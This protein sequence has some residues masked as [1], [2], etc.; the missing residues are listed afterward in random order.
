MITAGF[1]AFDRME[2]LDFVGPYEVFGMTDEVRP[3]SFRTLVLGAQDRPVRAYHGL[4]VL[5]EVTLEEAPPLDLLVVP[6]GDGRKEAS[7]DPEILDFLRRT[8]Q[9][10]ALVASVCTGA[11][12]LAAAGLLEGREAT[13]H[14]HF[15]GELTGSH[16][17]IRLVRRRWVRDGNVAT[18]GGVTCGIDLSLALVAE[19]V[20]RET[21]N[22]CAAA[23]TRAAAGT[24]A[25]AATWTRA[26][27]S[28]RWS[29]RTALPTFKRARASSTTAT[30]NASTRK[31]STRR[32]R[33]C[34][35]SSSPRK[36]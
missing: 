1:L 25:S 7:R 18:A 29:S 14:H 10:G 33:C 24:S 13:T 27:S 31:R 20:D 23:L 11:F 30:P 36:D 12:V 34:A 6:G 22:R 16:P 3:G 15:Y 28:A 9:S 17:G 8:S 21:A 32:R 4:R 5:P 19:L 2:E 35:P 26:S